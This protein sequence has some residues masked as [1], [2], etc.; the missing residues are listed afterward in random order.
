MLKKYSLIYS[1]GF[2]LI[3]ML[4]VIA[5]M[6]IIMGGSIAGYIR[7]NDRQIVLTAGKELLTNIRQAQ[8]RATSGVKTPTTC[9]TLTGYRIQA[10]AGASSY[11][12]DSVCSNATYN[13]Q[14]YTLPSGVTF[15]SAVSI[16][17][18][19][20]YGGV[21]G[22]TAAGT[23]ITI[24]GNSLTYVITINGSGGIIDVGLQ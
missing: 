22:V 14:T 18:Q 3:E 5:I 13:V 8:G 16:V 4:V 23:N 7:F 10:S 24:Q 9:T 17:F 20:Q 1:A 21:T 6:G 15:Q 19:G 11:T 12:L 2:T